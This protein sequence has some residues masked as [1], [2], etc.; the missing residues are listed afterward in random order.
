MA[1]S[2]LPQF[3]SDPNIAALTRDEQITDF[4]TVFAHARSLAPVTTHSSSF[5]APSPSPAMHLHRWVHTVLNAFINS[6]KSAPSVSIGA[7]PAMPFA[8]MLTMSLVDV[9]PSMLTMLNV[10]AMSVLTAFCSIDGFM[11]Q[12]V[13]MNTS[14]VAM[15]G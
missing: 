4:A 7:L 13:V 1:Q 12:S 14:I 8:M 9:S 3:A 11:A 6:S 5:D 10:S 15:L 2:T